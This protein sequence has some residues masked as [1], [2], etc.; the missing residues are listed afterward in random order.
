LSAHG[1]LLR[2]GTLG[3]KDA[4][5]RPARAAALLAADALDLLLAASP[6]VRGVVTERQAAW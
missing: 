6:I 4:L 5:L 1:L 3:S 2:L